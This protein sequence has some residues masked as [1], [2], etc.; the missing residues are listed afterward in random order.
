VS[1]LAVTPV[2]VRRH[3]ENTFPLPAFIEGILVLAKKIL[4][5]LGILSRKPAMLDT[6][7][8]A[9]QTSSGDQTA[10]A[11][12]AFYTDVQIADFL[13]W[14]AV[15][16]AQDMV[17]DPSFGAGVFLRSACRRLT[18]LGGDPVAQV[19]GIEVNPQVYGRIADK[20][21]DEFQVAKQNLRLC[22]FFDCHAA[23]AHHVDVIVGNPPFIR[24]Q[25]FTGDVRKRALSC[26]RRQGVHLSELS[27]SWAPFLVHSIAMLKEG[28]RLAMVVPMEVGHA[29][30]AL[31]VL[32]YLAGAFERVTF[33]T[34]QKKLFPDLSEDT[35]L[36]LAENK[37][38]SPSAFFAQDLSHPGLLLGLQ[39]ENRPIVDTQAMNTPALSEGRERLVEYLI[40]PAARELYHELKGLESTRRLGDLADVGI[41]YVTG[42]NDFFHLDPQQANLWEI[43]QAFLKQAIRRGR[44][45][46]GLR[47]T[48]E[49]W[50]KAVDVGQ[51]AYLLH[52]T[53]GS[54]L[55]VGVRRYLADGETQGIPGAYKCRTR[56]P[57]FC[58]P[59]VHQP[60]AFLTYMSGH[61][62]SLVAN[63]AG[64]VAPNSL[65]MVRLHGGTALTSEAIAA[66]WFTSLTRLSAEIE[67]HALGGGMLKLEPT[68]AE[69]VVVALPVLSAETSSELA[70]RLDT[71]ARAGRY[72]EAQDYADEAIL[73]EGIG[74]SHGD[75]RLLRTAGDTLRNRRYS[76]SVAA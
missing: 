23:A 35:L 41:G 70:G 4:L 71:L 37:G 10:K 28:G 17:M 12:G 7:D 63:E 47:F 19:F 8:P 26:A 48:P 68:E 60:D 3:R 49:D 21:S 20:L 59:H 11:L 42:A 39:V 27:S 31:P 33:L 24:Y 52:I 50:R 61:T 53:P 69:N 36:L 57:W 67:G 66:L 73:R 16:S 40:P 38:G 45:L 46:S 13:V 2:S 18:E 72:V 43:P 74:L 29:R 76:R 65:H 9:I 6:Q 22:D 55:P 5:N 64:V 32:R 34:F 44:A 1:S 54:E 15:R 75:C 30:Y 14:W 62:P 58:V 25:R 51:G 56:S